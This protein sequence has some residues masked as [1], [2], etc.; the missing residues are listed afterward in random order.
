MSQ[1]IK[2]IYIAFGA[3]LSNPKDT[4]LAAIKSLETRGIN[5]I[6]MSGLWQSPA[7]PKGSGQPDYINACAEV[8]FDSGAREVSLIQGC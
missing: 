6:K 7:W 1:N 4:F 2:P 5:L 3:N 8:E